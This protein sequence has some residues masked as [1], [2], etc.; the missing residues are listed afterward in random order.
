MPPPKSTQNAAV[1]PAPAPAQPPPLLSRYAPAL[2]A[3]TASVFAAGSFVARSLEECPAT[4][5]AGSA[6]AEVHARRCEIFGKYLR[7]MSPILVVWVFLVVLLCS[8]GL[9]WSAYAVALSPIAIPVVLLVAAVFML[10]AC[11][12]TAAAAA[13]A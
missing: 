5:D 3:A 8:L 11:S 9:L 2:F 4:A 7:C 6:Q 10:T 13:A 1:A 12:N